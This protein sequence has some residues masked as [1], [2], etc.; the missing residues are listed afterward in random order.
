MIQRGG[1]TTNDVHYSQ[2]FRDPPNWL[3]AFRNKAVDVQGL[4]EPIATK[5][6]SINNASVAHQED[7]WHD[8]GLVPAIVPPG[9]FIDSQSLSEAMTRGQAGSSP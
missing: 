4:P 9:A 1:L 3:T 5:W 2:K 6:S 7:F 8:R